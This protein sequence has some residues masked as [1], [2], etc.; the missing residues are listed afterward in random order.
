[1]PYTKSFK[2]SVLE[3][4]H[5]G[6]RTSDVCRE[7]NLPRSTVYLWLGKRSPESRQIRK[8][9]RQNKE[10]L[11][12]IGKLALEASRSKKNYPN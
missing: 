10:L 7:F 4:I 3:R 9:K 1:M 2:D 6:A 12:I 11:E 5:Q 8:L